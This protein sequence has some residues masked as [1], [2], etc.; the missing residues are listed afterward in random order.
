MRQLIG[1]L[2]SGVEPH[3]LGVFNKSGFVLP[4]GLI[5]GPYAGHLKAPEEYKR[6]NQGFQLGNIQFFTFAKQ[7]VVHSHTMV[8]FFR[9]LGKFVTS[10][11]EL[12]SSYHYYFLNNFFTRTVSKDRA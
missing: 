6:N 1:V 4:V 9:I 12:K 11:P 3:G 10:N 7:L 8:S 5:F 2:N